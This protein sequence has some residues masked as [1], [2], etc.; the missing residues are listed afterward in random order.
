MRVHLTYI[1]ALHEQGVQYLCLES[2]SAQIVIICDGFYNELKL[3]K[4]TKG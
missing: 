4:L 2:L 3:F 1:G